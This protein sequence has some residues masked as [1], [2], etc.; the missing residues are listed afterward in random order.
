MDP[1]DAAF[2]CHKKSHQGFQY[3]SVMTFSSA[4]CPFSEVRC[5]VPRLGLLIHSGFPQIPGGKGPFIPPHFVSLSVVFY[6][7]KCSLKPSNNE[8]CEDHCAIF[9]ITHSSH[10]PESRSPEHSPTTHTNSFLEPG[11]TYR[12]VAFCGDLG[13]KINEY[14]KTK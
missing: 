9:S 7:L 4:S 8:L 6:S 2:S 13:S 5:L 12:E 11:R 3:Y 14:S 1:H 10:T